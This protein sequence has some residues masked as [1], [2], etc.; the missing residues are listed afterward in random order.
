MSDVEENLNEEVERG[1]EESEVGEESGEDAAEEAAEE[2]ESEQ[3]AEEAKEE[4]P[5]NEAEAKTEEPEEE[6]EAEAEKEAK[7]EAKEEAEESEPEVKSKKAHEGWINV[8]PLDDSKITVDV[9]TRLRELN[10]TGDLIMPSGRESYV[11]DA[12]SVTFM[13]RKWTPLL[14][15]DGVEAGKLKNCK[16]FSRWVKA[17]LKWHNMIVVQTKTVTGKPVEAVYCTFDVPGDDSMDKLTLRIVPFDVLKAFKE[18]WKNG[19]A[20]GDYEIVAWSEKKA[21]QLH[22][23]WNSTWHGS[24]NPELVNFE[25]LSIKRTSN[26]VNSSAEKRKAEPKEAP[27]APKASKVAHSADIEP[28]ESASTTTEGKEMITVPRASWEFFFKFYGANE[29]RW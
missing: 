8:D 4:E 13:S 18:A 19:Y 22:K 7:E 3:E 15:S 14:V 5:A 11:V 17:G 27:S 24:I 21:S 16:T 29:D 9:A 20:S 1:E 2:E 25:K 26:V 28:S 23:L 12:F 6:A 10:I